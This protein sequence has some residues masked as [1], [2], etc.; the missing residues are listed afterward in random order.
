MRNFGHVE[1]GHVGSISDLHLWKRIL[2]M[3]ASYSHWLI[4]AVILSF[5][6][7][8]STLAL[9]YLLQQGIDH[10]ILA[11]DLGNELRFSGLTGVSLQY[12]FLVAVTF[13]TS[14]FQV[15]TLEWLGQSV[16]HEIRQKL[17]YH[18][19]RLDLGFLQSQP[20]GRLI[21]RLTNDIQNMHE[22]FTSVLVTLFNDSLRIV[23]ILGLLFW[24]DVKLA[25]MMSLFVPVSALITYLFSRYAREKFAAIRSQLA[26]MN[27]FL[28]ESLA[29]MSVIQLF[30]QQLRSKKAFWAL[31]EEYLQR[32][33][34][35]IRLFGTFLPVTELLGTLAMAIIL[36]VGGNQVIEKELSIGELV[37]F[38]AYMRLFFQPLRELSQK[39]SIVQSALASA[40]RIFALLDKKNEIVDPERPVAI[41]HLSGEVEFRRI[42][43]AYKKD[44]EALSDVSLNIPAGSTVALV[45]TTGSGKSTLI[46]LLVRFYEPQQG[47]VLLDGVNIQQFAVSELRRYIGVVLQEVY[48]L[49]DSLL[50]NIVMDTGVSRKEVEHI[51]SQTAMNRFV[52]RLPDGLDTVI[53]EG[54][55][56]LSTGEKQLLSFARILCRNPQVLI[57]DE[58]TASI[59]TESEDILEQTIEKAFENRTS[60]IIAHRLS[61]IR[62]ANYIAVMRRGKVI[63]FGRH[64]E[65][66]DQD[67]EYTK[68]VAM[69]QVAVGG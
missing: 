17:F 51:L 23:G 15:I 58:A 16:M 1:D 63:E 55:H 53:G 56:E 47:E 33:L 11:D 5:V 49:Q 60:I 24:M 25:S 4:L 68:L 28:G 7:T 18:V 34:R 21:T 65:L 12:G 61:T 20:T 3:T 30:A 22:M 66:L 69:D 62:R 35:Q 39:Y 38:I 31:S 57:L 29:G 44:E 52:D 50:A 46:N 42:H 54:G 27:A 36:L 10:W 67:G 8:F 2:K 64:Q 41:D 32:C 6:V 45:G 19:T 26:V 14:F 40:E 9:P 59:D 37:A 13:F 43:F 48:I